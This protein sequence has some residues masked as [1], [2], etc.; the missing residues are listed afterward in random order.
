MPEP[1]QFTVTETVAVC[2][3]EPDEAVTVTVDVVGVGVGDE[4]PP[5]QAATRPK[6]AQ[7]VISRSHA[8][9]RRR[10]IKPTRESPSAS[11]LTGH[12][13]R[14]PAGN[15]AEFAGTAMVST[16]LVDW[17][18]V[19]EVGL[20]EQLAPAGNPEQAKVTVELKPFC[21]VRVNVTVPC[22]PALRV[23][24]AGEPAKVKVT[25]ST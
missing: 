12:V 24:D 1:G 22:P 14:S 6:L 10:R 23:S 25:G 7:A 19:T 15:A 9:R 2:R 18:G 11:A 5:P 20:N 21:G 16:S 8:G 3:I 4:E 13:E 17:V